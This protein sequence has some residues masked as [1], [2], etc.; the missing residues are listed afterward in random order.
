MAT[1]LERAQTDDY[2]SPWKEMLESYFRGFM[3][4]FFPQAARDIDWSRGHRFLDKELQQVVADAELGRRFA[5]KLAAVHRK[6]GSEAWVLTHIEVQGR[7]E[8]AFPK[9]M[10]TYNYRI[11]DR[12]D[13][14]VA[15]LAVLADEGSNW[16]PGRFGYELWGCEVGIRFPAVKLSDFAN[17]WDELEKSENPFATV[18]MA[19]LKTQQTRH[20]PNARKY[21]KFRLI[22]NLYER[23][24]EKDDILNLFR[25][26]DWLMR[27]PEGLEREFW[28]EFQAYEEG[29]S[30]QYVTSVERFGIEKG[31]EQGIEIGLREGFLETIE[32][33]LSLK[34]GRRGLALME[35]VKGLNELADVK[36][37]KEIVK[38]ADRIEDVETVLVQAEADREV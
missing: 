21:W 13:R 23:G 9:R 27:L 25:F 4:F 12:Y 26:M 8:T 7:H 36:Q 20:D 19:H 18:V 11:F 28:N 16:R 35:R 29:R 6:G 2:D 17:Q 31:I 3:E 38:Q 1:E 10:F 30:M 33:L 14:P 22:R 32:S 24:W 15:S 34:F 5:D 37:V